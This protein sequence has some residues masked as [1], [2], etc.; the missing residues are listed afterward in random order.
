MLGLYCEYTIMYHTQ[1]PEIYITIFCTIYVRES[2]VT[3]NC[4]V[5]IPLYLQSSTACCSLFT[6]ATISRRDN[7]CIDCGKV[8][9]NSR[10]TLLPF[11][12]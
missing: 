4:D 2:F 11:S 7:Y 1:I 6:D 5:L 9:W 8:E 10:Y 3:P 12:W